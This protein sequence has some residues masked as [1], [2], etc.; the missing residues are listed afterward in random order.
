LIF[1]CPAKLQRHLLAE[2]LLLHQTMLLGP[3][4]KRVDQRTSVLALEV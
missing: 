1:L 2:D 3:L 4:V